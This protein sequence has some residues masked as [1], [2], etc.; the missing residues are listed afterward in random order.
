MAPRAA[1]GRLKITA[2]VVA[3]SGEV[4]RD[5]VSPPV[6]IEDA[7]LVLAPG[8]RELLQ[9]HGITT[10]AALADSVLPELAEPT[11]RAR[12]ILERDV[13]VPPPGESKP[14]ES[15]DSEDEDLTK[16]PRRRARSAS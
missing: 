5:T 3:P 2:D 6:V 10:V 8:M 11:K 13:V 12:A 16:R 9:K 7:V 1:P 14:D 4:K 15:P